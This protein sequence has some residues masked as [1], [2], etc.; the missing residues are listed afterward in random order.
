V[1]GGKCIGVLPGSVVPT[2]SA[3]AFF[4]SRQSY[5][6]S[7]NQWPYTAVATRSIVTNNCSPMVSNPLTD[8]TTNRHMYHRNMK[9]NSTLWEWKKT[10]MVNR[11]MGRGHKGNVRKTGTRRG[12]K[13]TARDGTSCTLHF[14]QISMFFIPAN[15][16]QLADN[17]L[18][19][20]WNIDILLIYH[21]NK[22]L[23]I[24]T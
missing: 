3:S 6:E 23:F 11:G 14:P 7:H 15:Y 24:M 21:L 1:T 4:L 18:D 19:T 10:K 13:T 22:F 2:F 16:Y 5:E 20:L 17:Q 9:W 12:R 8:T